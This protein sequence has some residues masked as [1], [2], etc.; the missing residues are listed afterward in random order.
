MLSVVYFGLQTLLQV[1]DGLEKVRAAR[2]HLSVEKAR[3]C[4]N[5]ETEESSKIWVIFN[6]KTSCLRYLFYQKHTSSKSSDSLNLSQGTHCESHVW[7]RPGWSC[8]PNAVSLAAQAERNVLPTLN[9][10]LENLDNFTGVTGVLQLVFFIKNLIFLSNNNN[11]H[12][13]N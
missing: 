4:S 8:G 5:G 3:R 9:N 1:L 2:G 11:Y 10:L 6:H 12:L 7:V 13:S